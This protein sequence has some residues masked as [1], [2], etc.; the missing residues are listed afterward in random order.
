MVP[1]F[2][3][4]AA[5]GQFMTGHFELNLMD[6][7]HSTGHYIGVMGISLGTLGV[8]FC[9][10][11]NWLA[12][13][14]LTAYYGLLVIWTYYCAVC[15]KKSND[16]RIVTRASKICI[17]I[18]LVMFNVYAVIL[19]VTCYASGQNEGNVFTSPFI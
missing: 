1:I 16:M 6:G 8:G 11:W 5:M 10:Q 12:V 9:L 3:Y 4:V 14:L 15:P 13:G 2:L 18:E 17:G 19:A 7:V